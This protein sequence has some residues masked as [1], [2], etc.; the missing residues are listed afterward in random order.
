M[1]EGARMS[2]K[3][4]TLIKE[5]RSA[6]GLT[7]AELAA[8]VKGLEAADIS[9]AERGIEEPGQTQLKEIAKVLGVTQASLLNAASGTAAKKTA[10]KT[11]SKTGSKT[12]SKTASG[13]V[14][15]SSEE[16][17]LLKL[18][19]AADK[20]KR[21]MAMMFLGGDAASTVSDS[22]LLSSSSISSMLESALGFFGKRELTEGMEGTSE[23]GEV[24]IT[25]YKQS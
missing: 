14:K 3:L 10:S 15:L 13:E 9:K 19:R 24:T 8:K 7:Q 23:D 20:S 21:A 16:K 1:K 22:G 2:K 17:K 6:A 4:G 18:Y 11:A 12:A 5:A 25:E